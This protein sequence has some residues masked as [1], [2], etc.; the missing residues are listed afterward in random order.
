[1]S[2]KC[3]PDLDRALH[4]IDVLSTLLKDIRG[5]VND[6]YARRINEALKEFET[7]TP[8]LSPSALTKSWD[9]QQRMTSSSDVT[10]CDRQVFDEAHVP[11]SMGSN[12]GLNFLQEVLLENQKSNETGFMGHN[13][14]IQWMRALERKLDQSGD[15]PSDMPYAAPRDSGEASSKHSD[16][17]YERQKQSAVPEPL[18]THYFC[19]DNTDINIDIDVP[20]IVPPVEIANEPFESYLVASPQVVRTVWH[21]EEI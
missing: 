12:D 3:A 11:A 9:E 14:Q 8:S 15:G 10:D 21:C 2:L 5:A 20:D 19:L 17:P 18:S 16:A 6:E 4:K 1:V 7:D 13:S